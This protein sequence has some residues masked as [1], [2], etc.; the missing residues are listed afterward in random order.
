MINFYVYYSNTSLNSYKQYNCCL[1]KIK[2]YRLCS[3]FEW[4]KVLH[5]IRK[6][7]YYAYEYAVFVLNKRWILAEDV[8]RTDEVVWTEYKWYFDVKD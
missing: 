7:P 1:C 4:C 2:D 5:I 3:Y 6:S 8:I